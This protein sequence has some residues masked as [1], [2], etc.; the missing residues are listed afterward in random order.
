MSME[1][2]GEGEGR[3]R[4]VESKAHRSNLAAAVDQT[5][6]REPDLEL[7]A[8]DGRRIYGHRSVLGILSPLLVDMFASTPCCQM[9]TMVFPDTS[10]DILSHLLNVLYTGSTEASSEA[11][12]ALTGPEGVFA[13]A[14][15]LGITILPEQKVIE[16]I[17]K[18]ENIVE[19]QEEEEEEEEQEEV[20]VM[21]EEAERMEITPSIPMFDL[22]GLA[23]LA[24]WHG[25]EGAGQS[26]PVEGEDFYICQLASCQTMIMFE[27]CGARSKILN[28]YTSHFQR[29]LEA[30][31][32]HLLT[33]ELQCTLCS[34]Q[35]G[36]YIKSKVWS[37]IGVTHDK[38]NE[39]LAS[40]G[41]PPIAVNI[42]Q[43]SKV[44]KRKA[45]EGGVEEVAPRF[46][47][48]QGGSSSSPTHLEERGAGGESTS[49]ST[50]A[51]TPYTP[52]TSYSTSGGYGGGGRNN[53][54]RICGQVTQNRKRLLKHYCTRHFI[55][56]LGALEFTFIVRNKCVECGRD[57]IGAKKSSKVIHIGVE[58]RQIFPI[59][60]AE[61]GSV[62]GVPRVEDCRPVAKRPRVGEWG[63]EVQEHP[64]TL[65]LPPPL[66]TLP[67]PT[68]PLVIPKAKSSSLPLVPV[69]NNTP[70]V[71]L[72]MSR[73]MMAIQAR[74]N[75]CMV[76]GKTFDLFRSMLLPHY[77]GHFYKEI[78]QGH[79]EYFTQENCKLCGARATKRK[80]RII[81]LGVKH[82]LVLPYI[83]EILRMR[84]D[85]M[86]EVEDLEEELEAATV[87]QEQGL[88]EVREVEEVGEQ[89]EDMADLSLV[90][91]KEEEE[92]E[93]EGALKIK[94]EETSVEEK[95]EEN[96]EESKVEE[97][98]AGE[99]EGEASLGCEEVAGIAPLPPPPTC[100]PAPPR[101]TAPSPAPPHPSPAPPA[102]S[103]PAPPTPRS[104]P[105]APRAIAPA[106]PRVKVQ[107]KVEIAAR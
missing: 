90:E 64:A 39:I 59:L 74:G 69:Q 73:A 58:H 9:A 93:E 35:L 27:N 78:A 81:H 30:E 23:T 44:G 76:C 52:T 80:S 72:D 83:Q 53:C 105:T 101:S 92:E 62:D 106:P 50:S 70:R 54:C 7:V 84:G 91:V 37:H 8:K 18:K 45:S 21:G 55:D 103:T 79:E 38:T 20:V 25:E 32:G 63:E 10:S 34:K 96:L 36:G 48:L 89:V 56:R 75:H 19:E 82:E 107:E 66:P 51:C 104:T 95:K 60:E 97:E 86:E 57:F 13:T 26:V 6:V 1:G 22:A 40:R 46:D 4:W 24:Q 11:M 67:L 43:G 47:P 77:C 85:T 28:H 16:V 71:S 29:E 33:P 31:F 99:V 12:A 87:K 98:L 94:E 41:I 17:D 49:T 14:A 15:L 61:F 5:A 42:R 88:E 100:S 68:T 102:P 2:E 3:V 65:P